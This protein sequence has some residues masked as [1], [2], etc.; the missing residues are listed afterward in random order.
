MYH[1][2]FPPPIWAQV[3]VLFSTAA[4][5][6]LV[7]LGMLLYNNSVNGVKSAHT[8]S[9]YTVVQLNSNSNKKLLKLP[10]QTS[11]KLIKVQIGGKSK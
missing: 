6:S 2:A 3:D 5:T 7:V 1:Q 4:A 10:R 11:Q 8:L 9:R